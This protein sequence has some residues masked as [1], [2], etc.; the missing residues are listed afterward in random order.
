MVSD[1]KIFLKAPL[2]P[3]YTN[4]EGGVRA[5]KRNFLVKIFHKVPKNAFFGSFFKILPAAQKILPKQGLFS[6]LEE[7]GKS[8][9]ST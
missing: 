2:A 3:I 5:K 9:W 4:F 7:L 8:I 1:L 6:V